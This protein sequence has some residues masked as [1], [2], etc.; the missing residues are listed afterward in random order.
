MGLTLKLEPTDAGAPRGLG[1]EPGSS[2]SV[3]RFYSLRHLSSPSD[4]NVSTWKIFPRHY[5]YNT[6]CTSNSKFGSISK[7][8]ESD[9]LLQMDSDSQLELF[10]RNVVLMFH[11]RAPHSAGSKSR[12]VLQF[13]Y[14]IYMLHSVIL[15]YHGFLVIRLH[16]KSRR[17]YMSSA[18]QF[19]QLKLNLLN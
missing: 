12:I 14:I 1:N 9:S 8:A 7:L 17:M 2:E 18:A 15:N 6:S 19:K 4:K 5:V 13:E 3:S 11:S 10:S 16:L